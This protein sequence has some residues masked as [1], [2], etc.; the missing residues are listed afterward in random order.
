MDRQPT[1][2]GEGLLLRPLA[3][4]DQA[5]LYEAARDPLIWAQHPAKDRWLPEPFNAF[6][7]AAVA[8][9][10]A[11]LVLND[12]G[13]VLGTSRYY[14]AQCEDSVAIGYTFLRRSHWGGAT[15]GQVKALMLDHA[16]RSVKEVRF[17]VGRDNHR[18]QRALAKLGV[19]VIAPPEPDPRFPEATYCTFSL[20][21]ERWL[22]R[23]ASS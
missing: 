18:S 1:L 13:A 11:L 4:T 20:S 5:A 14:D 17:H 23:S 16:F 3:A 19:E 8:S 2:R 15:N 10:G 7:E 12:D 9:G 22:E 21:R 6:F